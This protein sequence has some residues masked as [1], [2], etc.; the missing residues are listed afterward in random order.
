MST[1]AASVQRFLKYHIYMI[2]H[3]HLAANAK[4]KSSDPLTPEQWL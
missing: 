1:G 4:N 2:I 3:H